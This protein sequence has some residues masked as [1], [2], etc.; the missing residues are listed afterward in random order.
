MLFDPT[1]EHLAVLVRQEGTEAIL[2]LPLS[3][4]LPTT[5]VELRYLGMVSWGSDGFLYAGT[6]SELLRIPEAGGEPEVF[7]RAEDLDGWTPRAHTP[8]VHV[9]PGGR[10][11]LFTVL[12]FMGD[13]RDAEI[14]VVDLRAGTHRMLMPGAGAWYAE[15]GHLLTLQADGTLLGVPFDQ[16]ALTIDGI[17]VP[18]LDDIAAFSA[19]DP[20]RGMFDLDIS[21]NGTLVYL[22]AGSAETGPQRGEVVWVSRSGAITPVDLGWQFDLALGPTLSLSPDGTQLVFTSSTEATT[23]FGSSSSPMDP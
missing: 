15:T 21:A 10:G 9:L 17:P 20:Q 18:L 2:R 22:S 13:L 5:L 19:F 14:G 11:V 8:Y 16:D 6:G 3:G 12:G 7:L 23:T 1:G 4:G